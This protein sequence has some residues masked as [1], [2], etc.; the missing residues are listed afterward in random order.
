LI[1]ITNEIAVCAAFGWAFHLQ[2][3]ELSCLKP[4]SC[5][6]T[7]RSRVPVEWPRK[8]FCTLLDL[9]KF[10]NF[11]YSYSSWCCVFVLHI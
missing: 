9:T 4:R 7:S 8:C 5:D 6:A 11:R 3:F 10:R 2:V 1:R